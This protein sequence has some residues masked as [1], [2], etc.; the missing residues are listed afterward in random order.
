MTLIIKKKHIVSQKN[1]SKNSIKVLYRLNNLGYEAYLV[2]GS[3]RDLL[4]GIKPQDFD[5]VTNA[6]P[7][8]IRKI[9]KNCRLVGKR[10]IVA[11]LIF[12]NE[13]V[14][15]STFRT[16]QYNCK[17]LE[18]LS[19][20]KKYKHG[21]IIHDNTFGKIEDDV[22]RRDLTINAL[23]FN[24]KDSSIR[25]YVGGLNDI[26][27]KIIRLIGDAETR[28]RED[29]VRMLRVI[30]FSVKLNMNISKKTAEPISRLA[31]LLKNIPS[32]R[33]FNESIK[34][35]FHGYG[36]LTYKKLKKYSLIQQLFPYLFNFQNKKNKKFLNNII[37]LTLKTIDN[38]IKKKKLFCPKF[39]FASIL[40]Y[41]FLSK[42]EKLTENK[43]INYLKAYLIS[44]N[45]ILQKSAIS[46]GIPKNIVVSISKIWTLQKEMENFSEKNITK[47]TKNKNFFNALE[48]LKL[49]ENT[50]KT[51]NLKKIYLF[52]IK[53]DNS[54]KI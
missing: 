42:I 16:T 5:V 52:W 6:T 2:G 48:L 28:Y 34:L 43:K 40:W 39:F 14:E 29:P 10:F 47:I 24:A 36:M 51:K 15:V 1:I 38:N 32:A 46:L 53:N 12:K 41:P 20:F 30:R 11:H 19:I 44:I 13:I 33:L 45:S 4:L 23:Y 3:I 35:F 25:D 22:Y 27:S 50:E 26:K 9:F 31:N 17:E 18:N 54:N 37:I 49:R 21:M 7:K 8:N